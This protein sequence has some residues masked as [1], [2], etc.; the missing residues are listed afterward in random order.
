MEAAARLL[1]QEDQPPAALPGMKPTQE[2]TGGTISLKDLG[3]RL[4]GLGFKVAEN[5]EFGGVGKHSP[6]SH[7]YSGDAFDLTIQPG[8]P[9][10]Q[11]KPDSA[12]RDL[13]GTY[14]EALRSAIPGA[15]VFNPR[16]DPVGGHDSHIHL[17]LPG[18]SKS[19]VR[20]TPALQRLLNMAS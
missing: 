19:G 10:L 6:N 16:H 15:E 8:S 17:G 20:L 12:W 9:L 11:G 14:G 7:H 3:Q 13:T 4:Q 5:P 1:G 18:A 2:A